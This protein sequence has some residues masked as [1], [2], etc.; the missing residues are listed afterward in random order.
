M[1]PKPDTETV[2]KIVNACRKAVEL[3]GPEFQKD[4]CIEECAELIHAIQ[5]NRRGRA[6]IEDM[7]EEIADVQ[8]MLIQMRVILNNDDEYWRIFNLKLEGLEKRIEKHIGGK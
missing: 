8:I 2:K 3:W 6:T 1:E 5:K 4:M 7:M